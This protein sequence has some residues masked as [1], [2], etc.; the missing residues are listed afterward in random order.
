MYLHFSPGSFLGMGAL[1]QRTKST[2]CF[3]FGAV[4]WEDMRLGPFTP[5]MTTM[6]LTSPF[7]FGSTLQP[8]MILAFGL[9]LALIIS[10]AF[11]ASETVMSFPPVTLIRAPLALETSMSPSNGDSIA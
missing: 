5:V 7:K 10:A 1:S 3:D 4:S 9:I 6:I 8:Q 11:S 2:P